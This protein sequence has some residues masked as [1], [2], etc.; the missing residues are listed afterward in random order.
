MDTEG[1]KKNQHKIVL[2]KKGH[3]EEKGEKRLS[4][5]SF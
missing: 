1:H 4:D 2:G 5:K 3:K